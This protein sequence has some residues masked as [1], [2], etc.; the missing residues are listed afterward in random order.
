ML[1]QNKMLNVILWFFFIFGALFLVL[2]IVLGIATEPIL[3]VFCAFGLIFAAVGGIPLLVSSNKAKS[4]AALRENG[5]RVNA[6]ITDIQKNTAISVNGVNP[7][8]LLCEGKDASNATKVYKSANIYSL[9]PSSEIGQ[10]ITVFVSRD[11][12]DQY[13]VD[14]SK[15]VGA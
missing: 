14:I 8:I 5:M 15:Y 3:F 1:K 7:Y 13:Y 6:V 12:P 10:P 2:G 4:V 11:N 9:L